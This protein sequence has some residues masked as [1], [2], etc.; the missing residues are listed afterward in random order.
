MPDGRLMHD[1]DGE[2]V[3]FQ[4][5]NNFHSLK[6]GEVVYFERDGNIH[7]IADGAHVFII[8]DKWWRTTDGTPTYYSR[9]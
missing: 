2:P 3:F 5:G 6:T 9:D 1:K 8:Q 7:A 4:K